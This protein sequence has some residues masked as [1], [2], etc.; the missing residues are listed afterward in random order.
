MP[1]TRP[2]YQRKIVA[3]DQLLPI[4]ASAR[5]SKSQTV[6]QCHGCFDIVHPGHIRYLQFAKSQGDILIVSITGD[7]GIT[8][9]DMRPYIPAELRAENLAALEPVD[10]V[11]IDPHETACEILQA[12]RPDVYVKGHEY[13]TSQDPRFLAERR[14]VEES[15]GRV[16]FSSGEVVFSSSRLIHDM[17]ESEQLSLQRLRAIC[18]RHEV[19]RERMSVLIAAIRT[20]RLLVVGDTRIERYVLCDGRPMASESPMMT[21]RSLSSMDYVGGAGFIAMQAAALGAN[22]SLVTR[23]G[24][25]QLANWARQTLEDSN[26][27][28]IDLGLPADLPRATRYLVDDHKLLR[29]E[30][31]ACAPLDSAAKNR[32]W[33][34]LRRRVTAVHAAILH[35]DGLG[36]LTSGLVEG[37]CNG[38]RK[39]GAIVTGSAT[40]AETA[41]A[42]GG[43]ELFA[44]SERRLR[45][46]FGSRDDGLSSVAHD[47]LARTHAVRML[48]SVGKR[49]VVT[50]DRPTQD[51]DSP[52][53]HGRLRSEYLPALEDRA[54]DRLG[55]GESLLTAATLA[56]AAGAN[57]MQAAY[58]GSTTAGLQLTRIGLVPAKAD[59]LSAWLARRPE[60][61]T[62]KQTAAT[63]RSAAAERLPTTLSNSLVS[64]KL[65]FTNTR[66]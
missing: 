51:R 5:S 56:L 22:V 48:V 43:L 41:G 33:Q 30:S 17:P 65:N 24:T 60:L 45:S 37:L 35:D 23:L 11:V 28:V 32:A 7:S 63:Q 26:I 3:L 21:L 64:G 42:F 31:G 25:S 12:T 34:L 44:C 53:W 18:R 13:E 39:C 9:G 38:L 54:I 4:I 59:E 58:L 47:A 55:C 62:P 19:D 49:G 6:V 2:D 10:Y 66:H 61:F 46:T 36:L 8:K 40:V 52:E 50:F 14:I 20:K 15:G 1:S 16:V 27:D 57:I 29:I